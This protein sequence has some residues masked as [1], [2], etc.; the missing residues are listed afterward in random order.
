MIILMESFNG[1][2][3]GESFNGK[4]VTPNF[5]KLIKQHFSIDHYFSNSV[6]TVKGQF[7]LFC[8]RTP[9]L[10]GKASYLLDGKK[11]SCLPERLKRKGYRTIF[12]QSMKDLEFDNTTEF[13]KSISF[14]EVLSPKELGMSDQAYQKNSI[15]W[16]LRDD[17]SFSLFFDHV[18]KSKKS[19][20]VISTITHHFPFKIVEEFSFLINK[21]KNAQENFLNSLHLSDYFLGKIIEQYKSSEFSKNS[22]LIVTADHSFPSGRNGNIFQEKGATEDSFKAPFVIIAPPEIENAL[23]ETGV[24]VASHLDIMP[25]LLD[26]FG[27]KEEYVGDGVS[28]FSKRKRTLSHSFSR[29]MDSG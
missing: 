12:Y 21:P 3:V 16:G 28:F 20:S 22:I 17:V 24:N 23:S 1:T 27:A 19:F 29:M 6:Q 2:Y 7:A 10:K 5:N 15:N 8:G 4:E 18:Q 13:F 9:L 25:T 11:L 26:L 14:D